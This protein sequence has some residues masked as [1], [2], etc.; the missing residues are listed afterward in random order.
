MARILQYLLQASKYDAILTKVS[1][2]AN[3]NKGGWTNEPSS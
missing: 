2:I 3:D 1:H